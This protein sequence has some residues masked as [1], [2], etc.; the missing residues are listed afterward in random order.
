MHKTV[1]TDTVSI[2]G[3]GATKGEGQEKMR[4]EKKRQVGTSGRV[5]VTLRGTQGSRDR[6]KHG[7]VVGFASSRR[8]GKERGSKEQGKV[9]KNGSS[10]RTGW[11]KKKQ[12]QS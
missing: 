9:G 11:T 3:P 10:S 4:N 2:T 7:G 1:R 8:Q 12:L 6:K 5:S